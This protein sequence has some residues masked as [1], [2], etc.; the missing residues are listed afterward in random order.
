MKVT[1]LDAR[2]IGRVVISFLFSYLFL[3]YIRVSLTPLLTSA[4]AIFFFCVWDR[5]KKTLGKTEWI[6]IGI[7]NA[8]LSFVIIICK[9]IIVDFNNLNGD[10]TGNYMT[11]FSAIDAVAL[12]VVFFCLQ[13]LVGAAIEK[14]KIFAVKSAKKELKTAPALGVQNWKKVVFISAILFLAWFPYLLVYY[15][16]IIYGD[17]L[18]SIREAVYDIGYSNHHPFF[19]TLFIK[20]CLEIGILLGNINWGSALYTMIQMGYIS[21]LLAYLICWLSHKGVSTILCT[22][23]TLFYA[24]VSCFP[25][26]AVSMWKDPIFSITIVFYSLK[27]YDFILSKGNLAH[28]K[29]FIAQIVTASLIIC[30]SRNNGIYIILLSCLF[31]FV[32]SFSRKTGIHYTKPFIISN[33]AVIVFIFVLTGPVY[34][35]VGIHK[36]GIESY[37]IPL[38]QMA[39]TVVYD[40]KMNDAERE[41]LFTLLPEEKYKEKYRPGLVDG[42]KWDESFNGSFFE[43]N[44]KTFLKVWAGLLVKNP[45][46]F[47]DSWI[48]STYGYWSPDFW[49]LNYFTANI[50]YGNL[51]SI[52][53]EDSGGIKP[54]NLLA[55]A[56]ADMKQV[57]SL[58]TPLPAIGMISWAMLFMGL[59]LCI[60]KQKRFLILLA[61]CLGNLMTLLIAT[62]IAY[63]PRYALCSIYF[64]PVI[65]LVPMLA[66]R[67]DTEN[68]VAQNK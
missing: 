37:G 62:P 27:L 68:N 7:F 16:G 9:H 20:L 60:L 18:S 19:Y 47:I 63:W 3:Y 4:F 48:L 58:F 21:T 56:P 66:G 38:Q 67:T 22:F 40:G 55:N 31:L 30:L 49:E 52:E 15:P 23:I 8:V 64:I 13:I 50:G 59:L 2:R 10:I 33:A 5:T 39:R 65:L 36:D 54:R 14:L 41:F 29:F 32:L 46:I 34:N 43:A 11:A 61:P 1:E 24:F 53:T 42:L 51:T 28:S 45:K 25:Q 12:L 57:F 6:Y 17:S 26:H 35:A 44:K